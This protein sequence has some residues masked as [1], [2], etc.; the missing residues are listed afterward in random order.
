[1]FWKKQFLSKAEIA[2]IEKAIADAE[3]KTSG[4]IRLYIESN[5]NTSLVI[6][7]AKEVF[8]QLNMQATKQRNGVLLYIA[9]KQRKM[10]I[11]GDEQIH[12]LVNDA[13]WQNIITE[14]TDNFKQ[15]KKVEGLTK[16]VLTIGE[17]LSTHFPY[18]SDDVNE[19][20]N[21]IVFGK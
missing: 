16:A 4:E 21:E 14:L 8:A 9:H 18:T 5:C 7:R 12:K 13:Y 2:I 15:D 11:W 20:N 10:A 19:L 17:T 3:L 6:D 1:M